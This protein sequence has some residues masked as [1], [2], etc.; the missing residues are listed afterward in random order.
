MARNLVN[1]IV[2][3]NKAT[4]EVFYFDDIQEIVFDCPV[5]RI[6]SLKEI[7]IMRFDILHT[8]LLRPDIKAALYRRKMRGIKLLSTVH[9]YMKEDLRNS[10][11]PVMAHLARVIWCC[12][13]SRFDKVVCLSQHMQQYYS[14]LVKKELLTYA[15][16]GR[17]IDGDTAAMAVDTADL[18]A[19][20]ALKERYKVAGGIGNV[21]RIKGFEQLVKMLTVNSSFALVIIGEGIERKPLEALAASLGVADRCLFLGYR[22]NAAAYYPLFDVYAMTS[23]SEGMP[24]VLLE[25]ASYGMPVV[26]SNIGIFKELFASDEVVFYP[27]YDIKGLSDSMDKAIRERQQLSGK[28]K[29]KFLEN[30]TAVAMCNRYLALYKSLL[31]KTCSAKKIND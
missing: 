30:Y 17:R 4:I 16:N 3:S 7:N 13:L 12:M 31:N 2:K 26:C 23:Y 10:Y 9:S 6:V 8:H 19:I 22:A 5:H 28:V 15:Y 14:P 18:T 27:L 25:A 20:N 11:G 24:L 29:R 1:E 21:T